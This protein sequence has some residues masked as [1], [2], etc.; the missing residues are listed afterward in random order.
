MGSITLNGKATPLE[1]RTTLAELLRSLP[2]P[3]D[4]FAAEVNGELV[5]REKHAERVLHDGDAVEV[6]TLVG[7]G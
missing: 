1:G 3:H 2:I 6:V 7:G 5:P 4:A